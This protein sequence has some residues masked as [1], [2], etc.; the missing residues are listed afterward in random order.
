MI[1]TLTASLW[2][3]LTMYFDY[4]LEQGL[5]QCSVFALLSS[6]L[7]FDYPLEQGLR[8]APGPIL[9]PSWVYFDYPLEQGLRQYFPALVLVYMV[10]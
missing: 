7:Y 2:R 4:P 10:F 9:N 1:N 8:H 6:V 5:R 3:E